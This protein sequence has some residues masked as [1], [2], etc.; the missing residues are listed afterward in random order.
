MNKVILV[1]FVIFLLTITTSFV[2]AAQATNTINELYLINSKTDTVIQQLMMET[3][4]ILEK[5]ENIF[6]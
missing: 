6:L 4:L 1:A 5:Q 2:A 3:K